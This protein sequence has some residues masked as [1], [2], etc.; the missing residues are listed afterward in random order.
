VHYAIASQWS[1][2]FGV[3]FTITNTGTTAIN[4]W[5]LQFSFANG[6]AVT[7]GWNGTFSQSGSAVTVTNLSYN[8]TIPAGGSPSSEPGFNGSWTGTNAA[9]TAF[10]LNGTACTVA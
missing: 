10:T 7:Q 5:T 8:G 2:G 9:P 6:Q 3:N 4:G 1:G